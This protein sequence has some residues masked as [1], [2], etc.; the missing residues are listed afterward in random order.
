MFVKMEMM[1]VLFKYPTDEII[2]IDPENEYGVLTQKENFD[3]EV[4][5]LSP[6]SPTKYN[7]FDIDLS[8]TE[9]GRDAVAVKSEFIMTVVETAKGY[10]L[11][12][13]EKSILDRC[14]HLAYYDYQKSE[15]EDQTVLPTLTTLYNILQEQEE[16]EAKQLALY[17]MNRLWLI[18]S[19]HTKVN[20]LSFVMVSDTLQVWQPPKTMT[21]NTANGT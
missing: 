12:S 21:K 20:R 11:T 15:G 10:K 16:P 14:I 2:I 7:I 13:E 9:E 18:M 5:K 1:D 6:N 3:G 4:L 19:L 8:F 17:R